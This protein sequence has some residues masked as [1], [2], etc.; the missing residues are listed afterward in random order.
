MPLLPLWKKKYIQA[1]CYP[2]ARG[3]RPAGMI[4]AATREL[5]EAKEVIQTSGCCSYA[6]R[7][8]SGYHV[9]IYKEAEVLE[10][11]KRKPLLSESEQYHRYMGQ[12]FG[13]S[14]KYIDE[15]I[16]QLKSKR[17]FQ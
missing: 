3:A 10:R 11:I 4:G 6:E 7:H 17:A 15:F 9:Y 2:I 8:P 16:Q 12:L 14:D 13:Y 1:L 5:A